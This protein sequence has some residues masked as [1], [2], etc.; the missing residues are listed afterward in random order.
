MNILVVSMFFPPEMGAPAGR[1]FDFAQH[2]V[3]NG[4]RVTVITGFPNFPS[5]RI[6]EGY[7]G[8]LF[9]REQID[10]IDVWRCWLF[11]RRGRLGRPLAYASW[12]LSATLVAIGGRFEA[13]IV[14]AT[15]PPPLVGLPGRIAAW[16]RGVPMVFDIRDIWPEA[17]VQ[18]GRLT[19][20][21]VIQ[22]FEWVARYLYRHSSLV[23]AVTEGW[24]ERLVE[25][26]VPPHKSA[27]LPNGV[28]VRGFDE[29]T[30]QPLPAD[31][32]DLDP[33]A[34][35][36]TYAGIFNTPQGLEVIL[37]AAQRLKQRRPELYAR[38]QFV[39]VGEGPQELELKE[40]RQRLG[41]DRVHFVPRQ[42]RW[43]IYALLHRSFAVLVTLR[44]RKDTSTVPSKI[45]ECMASGRPVLFS[46]AGLGANT[47]RRAG[48][49]TVTEPADPDSLC[50]AICSYLDDPDRADAHGAAG[51]NFVEKFYDRHKIAETFAELLSDCTKLSEPDGAR[52]GR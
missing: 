4:H 30:N 40:M 24:I 12:L 8:R 32:R 10:G 29:D 42:P 31:F 49:G 17:I 46:A 45:Y 50:D 35:W 28:D 22:A 2:W 14:V 27:V 9:Q 39:L 6:H 25:L 36:F 34:Q 15:S 52:S 47:I 38:S 7:R 3:R 20:P 23:T 33:A 26:G 19:N 37:E 21:M 11:T 44:P 51:R 43:A 1:F 5:G 48:G 13:D 16:R 41:L 18:S